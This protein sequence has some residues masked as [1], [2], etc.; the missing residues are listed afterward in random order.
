MDPETKVFVRKLV[1]LMKRASGETRSR[2]YLLQKISIA[3]HRGNPTCML[4][5]LRKYKVADIHNL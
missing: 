2:D 3:I 4:R 1:N 5:T